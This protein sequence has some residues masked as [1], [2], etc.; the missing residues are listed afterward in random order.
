MYSLFLFNRK[1]KYNLSLIDYSQKM[2]INVLIIL[3][4]MHFILLALNNLIFQ[5]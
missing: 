5:I 4:R 3:V 1:Q 2:N